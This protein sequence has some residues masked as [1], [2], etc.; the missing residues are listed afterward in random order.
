MESD[1]SEANVPATKTLPVHKK[2]ASKIPSP[3]SEPSDAGDDDDASDAGVDEYAP[4]L[5]RRVALR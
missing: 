4:C 5:P 2:T 1:S 3:E